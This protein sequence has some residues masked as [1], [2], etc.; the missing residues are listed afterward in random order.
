MLSSSY[1][2]L[3]I[4]WVIFPIIVWICAIASKY[5]WGKWPP[6][7]FF[8][9]GGA[10]T[11]MGLAWVPLLYPAM[12]KMPCYILVGLALV[13]CIYNLIYTLD[14]QKLKDIAEERE[15]KVYNDWAKPD[16]E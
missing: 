16:P 6:R 7:Q 13:L 4:A 5:R 10:I 3:A 12:G 1:K 11:C 2:L 8:I 9:H 15:C 14:Q